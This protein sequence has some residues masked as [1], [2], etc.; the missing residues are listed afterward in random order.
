MDEENKNKSSSPKIVLLC[1]I[2]IFIVSVIFTGMN[3]SFMRKCELNYYKTTA[4]VTKLTTEHV[5]G[6]TRYRLIY[7]YKTENGAEHEV[8]DRNSFD[9]KA[10]DTDKI[11]VGETVEIYVDTSNNEAIPVSDADIFSVISVIVFSLAAIIYAVG[12]AILLHENGYG[13]KYRLLITWLPLA[14]VCI[15]SVFTFWAGLPN[16]TFVEVFKSV[17]G[18]IGY[19]VIAGLACVAAAIDTLICKKKREKV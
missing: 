19:T 13:L 8:A 3:I 2:F 15:V 12:S 1:A 18:A 16:G 5:Q 9:N 7:T 4:I 14:A 11:Y 17:R 6:Y 10:L